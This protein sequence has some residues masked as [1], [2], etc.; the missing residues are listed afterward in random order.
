MA[1]ND[2]TDPRERPDDPAGTK[3]KVDSETLVPAVRDPLVPPP[4]DVESTAIEEEP[5]L[6]PE[7][8]AATGTPAALGNGIDPPEA[9][10]FQ[11]LLGALFA[12]GL[13]ALVGVIVVAVQGKQS[14]AGP[15]T[16]WSPW[17]PTD[18]SHP[19]DQIASHVS[20]EYRL[21]NR[22]QLVLVQANPL[23]V[24]NVPLQIVLQQASADGGNI[25]YVNGKGVL[26]RMCGLGNGD[27]SIPGKPSADRFLLIRREALELALYTFHFTDADNVVAFLPPSHPVKAT[28]TGQ[29]VQKQ[30]VVEAMFFRR[31][32]VDQQLKQPLASTLTLR[33]PL[34]ATVTQNP[35]A[36]FVDELT[37]ARIFRM[38]LSPSNTDN[39]AFLVLQPTG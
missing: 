8:V 19:T 34:P 13:A 36:G 21:G 11:F 37:Q 16:N 23:E 35:D 33:A 9:P 38:T 6:L 28:P 10:R 27:C 7:R 26:Y 12:L 4:S 39:R 2:R 20:R 15:D 1:E 22:K 5:D 14:P 31:S 3:P 18:S 32:D 17:H 25:S 24:N 30:K 29:K